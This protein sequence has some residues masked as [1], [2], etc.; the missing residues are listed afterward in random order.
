MGTAV[1]LIKLYGYYVSDRVQLLQTSGSRVHGYF[2]NINCSLTS[3]KDYFVITQG[4]SKN[5]S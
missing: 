4:S 2:R 1:S 3:A 5:M